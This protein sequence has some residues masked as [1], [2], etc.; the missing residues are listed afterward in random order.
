MKRE[1]I[2]TLLRRW[3]KAITA[4]D[5]FDE[6]LAED[7]CDRSS[8]PPTRGRATFKA[9]AAAIRAALADITM[10]IDDCI[11]DAHE[12]APRIAWRWT[13]TGTHVGLLF[14]LAPTQLRIHLRGVNFQKLRDG[15]V[16]EHWTMIDAFGAREQIAAGS[17]LG[18]GASSPSGTG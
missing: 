11:I 1:A 14:G 17:D 3:T 2:D 18:S 5:S 4:G 9:R 12:E 7:V 15:V 13:L 10:T 16:V 6:L 8:E